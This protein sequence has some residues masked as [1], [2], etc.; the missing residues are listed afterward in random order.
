MIPSVVEVAGFLEASSVP[1]GIEHRAKEVRRFDVEAWNLHLREMDYV[2]VD[3]M[4]AEIW[5]PY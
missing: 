1:E 3:R 4:R 2:S 5:P